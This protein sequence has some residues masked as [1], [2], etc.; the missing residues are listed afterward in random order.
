ML[1]W[2]TFFLSTSDIEQSKGGSLQDTI[3]MRFIFISDSVDNQLDGWLIDDIYVFTISIISNVKNG[4][5]PKFRIY[6]NPSSSQVYVETDN[7]YQ[8]LEMEIRNLAGH[9]VF[10]HGGGKGSRM[11]LADVE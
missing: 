7:D 5:K 1:G 6:P 10:Y 3:R 8:R 4:S 9:E 11:E 2:T